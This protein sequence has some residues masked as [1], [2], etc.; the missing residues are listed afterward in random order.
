ML[1]TEAS[2][3]TNIDAPIAV[4]ATLVSLLGN[5]QLGTISLYSSAVTAGHNSTQISS[6]TYIL[7]NQYFILKYACHLIL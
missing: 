4:L 2:L 3:Q 1:G 6:E 5:W 7:S